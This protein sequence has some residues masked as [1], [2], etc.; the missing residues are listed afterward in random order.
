MVDTVIPPASLQVADEIAIH[1]VSRRF[2]V[3]DQQIQAL[4]NVSLTVKKGEFVSL[5]GPSGCGKSTLLRMLA[6]LDCPDSGEVQAGGN[7]IRTPSLSRG[8]VFQ[9]HRLLPW[10][11]V[12]ENILL[13]LK[14]QDSSPAEQ[15]RRVAQLIELVGLKGFEKAWPHQLSGGMSQRA[16]IARCLAPQPSILLLDE[17]F[18]ALDSLTR[19][20][21]QKALL[22]IWQQ[23]QLTTV[24]VTH[25]ID[26]ALYLSDRIVVLKP[27]PGRVDSQFEVHSRRPRVLTQPDLI[28]VKT[29]IQQALDTH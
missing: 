16:A 3:N 24:L 4:D 22:Q 6:G 11:N 26:E 28:E 25:D 20:H 14:Q 18:G 7:T 9:D 10:L 29:K 1:H 23:H 21:L 15:R 8:I 13:S 5:I 2:L 27:R 19:R 12:E 17:P